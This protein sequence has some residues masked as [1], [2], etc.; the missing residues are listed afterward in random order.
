M[1]FG[2]V[3]FDDMLLKVC[4]VV[5]MSTPPPRQ[6]VMMYQHSSAYKLPSKSLNYYVEKTN[7]T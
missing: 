2:N 4:L 1:F 6:E 5:N 3:V 7:R